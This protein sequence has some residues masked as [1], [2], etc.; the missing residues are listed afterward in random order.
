MAQ[1]C[2]LCLVHVYCYLFGTNDCLLNGWATMK[3][4]GLQ[5]LIDNKDPILGNVTSREFITSFTFFFQN[6]FYR[7]L[8][9]SE[10]QQFLSK[11]K[12]FWMMQWS[13]YMFVHFSCHVLFFFH[14]CFH[15]LFV[16]LP[17]APAW[18]L[19]RLAMRFQPLWG[20]RSGAVEGDLVHSGDLFV[21]QLG[22][23]GCWKWRFVASVLWWNLE[24][25]LSQ[26]NNV[27][28]HSFGFGKPGDELRRR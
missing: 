19:W 22:T 23:W 27:W 16:S 2:K 28:Q 18:P 12:K 6:G 7:F 24:F 17:V 9:D 25:K 14:V 21:E 20:R 3:R 11:K 26:A 5:Q 15:R 10:I 4:E 13:I 8:I 1:A